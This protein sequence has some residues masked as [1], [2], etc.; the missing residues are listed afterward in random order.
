[1]TGKSLQG[2]A[3]DEWKLYWAQHLRGLGDLEFSLAQETRTHKVI[4]SVFKLRD[5]DVD[6]V[7]FVHLKD[8]VDSW[9]DQWHPSEN[10][11]RVVLTGAARSGD[12]RNVQQHIICTVVH[13]P[14]W[15]FYS[16]HT[17]RFQYHFFLP[18]KG[19][20]QQ[21]EGN[22]GNKWALWK[23]GRRRVVKSFN[24]IFWYLAMPWHLILCNP[25]IV[26]CQCQRKASG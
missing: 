7:F 13:I 21:E 4:I 3:S 25:F 18:G 5:D 11:G 17:K 16:S 9:L 24:V 6:L 14:S 15:P 26:M 23:V 20:Q 12:L 19:F 2:G 10:C 8:N 1:M 22:C